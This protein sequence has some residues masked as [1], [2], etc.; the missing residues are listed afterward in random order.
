MQR[1]VDSLR[2]NVAGPTAVKLKYCGVQ[3][4]DI[5]PLLQSPRIKALNLSC[6]ISTV[7]RIKAA[8]ASNV[9]LEVLCISGGLVLQN[10][11]LSLL[12][13]GIAAAPKLRHLRLDITVRDR[14]VLQQELSELFADAL[15]YCKNS[16][17]ENVT[18]RCN[19]LEP[20]NKI[21]KREAA[22][23][24]NFNHERR[25]YQE[26]LRAEGQLLIRALVQAEKTDNH[27]LRYWLVRNHADSLPRG[28]SVQAQNR[29]R[30]RKS[31][32]A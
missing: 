26:K 17:L 21:W 30:K 2:T 28:E 11:D 10:H 3:T 14:N 16:S 8:L 27:H 22:P 5:L 12:F 4:D 15:K 6:S 24:L 7:S 18:L 20:D 23:I 1:L 19:F 13:Q 29:H 9:A 25:V 32:S 31:F